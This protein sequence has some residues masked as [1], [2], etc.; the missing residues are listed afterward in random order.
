[1]VIIFSVY[2]EG[3]WEAY[4]RSTWNYHTADL[5]VDNSTRTCYISGYD[6]GAWWFA[7]LGI[8]RVVDSV[9][10]SG[11]FCTSAEF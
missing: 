2:I 10:I 1:M 6:I 8:E 3:Q 5:A 9:I 7:D 4:Q 11:W